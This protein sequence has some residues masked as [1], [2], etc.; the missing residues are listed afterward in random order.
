MNQISILLVNIVGVV[1]VLSNVNIFP[2]EISLFYWE[3]SDWSK[4]KKELL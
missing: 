2:R 3:K 4:P 1:K